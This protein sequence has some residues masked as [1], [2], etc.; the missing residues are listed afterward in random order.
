MLGLRDR[1]KLKLGERGVTL[2][3]R[4]AQSLGLDRGEKVKKVLG[5]EHSGCELGVGRKSI[6]LRSWDADT[7]ALHSAMGTGANL[8]SLVLKL[9][10]MPVLDI[11]PTALILMMRRRR[12][13]G[14]PGPPGL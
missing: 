8:M 6:L 13:Q 7:K 5:Q 4:G 9:K 10:N 12:E 2:G 11:Y 3:A 14:W 1:L